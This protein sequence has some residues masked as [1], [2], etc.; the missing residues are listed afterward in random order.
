MPEVHPEVHVPY[1]PSTIEHPVIHVPGQQMQ[2]VIL[3]PTIHVQ[4]AHQEPPIVEPHIIVDHSHHHG[5]ISISPHVEV[6][7]SPAAADIVKPLVV[8]HPQRQPEPIVEPTVH[9]IHDHSHS[10]IDHPTV[11]VHPEV[12]EPEI[13]VKPI[14]NMI[15]SQYHHVADA[16]VCDHNRWY[17]L[18]FSFVLGACNLFNIYNL[19]STWKTSSEKPATKKHINVSVV[20]LTVA[21]IVSGCRFWFT[22]EYTD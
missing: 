13:V 15:G 2:P 16:P 22:C 6:T 10:I 18:G 20:I 11:Y 14:V 4:A 8:V 9:I 12:T 1:I 7:P 5:A 17:V 3:D 19:V 21:Y